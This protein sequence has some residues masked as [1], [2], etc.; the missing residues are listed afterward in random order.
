MYNKQPF[1]STVVCWVLLL[2]PIIQTYGWG[3]YDFA[4]IITS[5]LALISVVKGGFTLK[6]LP[7][8][9]L[10]YFIYWLVVHEI[11]ATSYSGFFPLGV[12]KSFLVYLLFF[13]EINDK[14]LIKSYRIAGYAVIAFFFFQLTLSVIIGHHPSGIIRSLPIALDLDDVDDFFYKQSAGT[15]ASSVFSEPAIFVQYILPLLCLELFGGRR[16]KWV[17]SV[18]I[19]SAILLAQSGNG[20]IGL[21]VVLLMLVI[22]I[23]KEKGSFAKRMF[24]LPILIVGVTFISYEYIQSEMGQRVMARRD[25]FDISGNAYSGQSGY[26]RMYR[27]YYVFQERNTLEKL[28]GNDNP[29]AI[30]SSILQ[31]RVSTQF[32]ENDMYFNTVQSVLIRT[33]IIGAILFILLLFFMFREAD[34][35]GKA[36]VSVFIV[37][38]FI[39]SLF[40]TETMALYLLLAYKKKH[41]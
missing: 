23:I 21:V 6:A 1:F 2:S 41:Q 22:Y 39:A 27:G 11:N 10:V 38:S 31:S 3:S 37:L 16:I 7:R 34:F 32:G 33:G 36:I 17:G 20:L 9:L 15:R 24:L 5:V 8:F 29:E 12:I 4:F 25:Q 18:I 14:Y 30:R 13:T 28:I 40:F 19:V 35:S 26:I